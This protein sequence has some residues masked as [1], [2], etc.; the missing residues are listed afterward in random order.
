MPP[1][2]YNSALD[3]VALI[4]SGETLWTHSMGATPRV[5]LDA[6]AK[7]ALT[8]DNLT[9]LQL[10]TEGAESL[11]HP[12]LKGHLRHRCFLV[13]Y[14]RGPCCKM[15]MR[16]MCRFFSLRSLSC[17]APVSKKSI[18]RLSKCRRPIN[19]ACVP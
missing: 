7:H 14:R 11:S 12:S 4:Q 8:K 15:V 19:T 1:I 10:H 18:P 3:A 5:L 6:L 16:I 13:A 17:F 9:L 2:K